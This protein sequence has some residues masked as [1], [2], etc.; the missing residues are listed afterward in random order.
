MLKRFAFIIL[1]CSGLFF[2]EN[3]FCYDTNIAHPGIAEIA[4]KVYNQ[5]FEQDLTDEEIG[6]IKQGT[7]EEDTPTRWM[8]HFYDPIYEKG[9]VFGGMTYSSAKNWASS[10]FTQT[11]YALGD[12]SWQRALDDIKKGDRKN[13]FKELGH[14]LHLIADMSVPAHTRNDV[15][16][17]DF[18]EKFVKLNW[19]EVL[20]KINNNFD[21]LN[22][23]S[24]DESFRELAVFS[25]NNFFSDDTILN[26]NYLSPSFDKLNKSNDYY[27]Y[28]IGQKSY[29]ILYFKESKFTNKVTE[30]YIDDVI[31]S[32]YSTILLPKA[33]AYSSGVIKL[34]I[35]E[36]N[37]IET[38]KIALPSSRESWT[39]FFN[40]A[41]GSL[42]SGAEKVY[43]LAK[44]VFGVKDKTLALSNEAGASP[45][46]K[47]SGEEEYIEDDYEEEEEENSE[48]EEQEDPAAVIE[49]PKTVVSKPQVVKQTSTIPTNI[50]EDDEDENDIEDIKENAAIINPTI[51]V[52]PTAPVSASYSSGG[53][54]SGGGSQSNTNT[55]NVSNTPNNN[56]NNEENKTNET[57]DEIIANEIIPDIIPPSAP[58]L[59]PIFS[60]T[61]YTTG[62]E[63]IISG[64]C[65]SDTVKILMS[66]SS[67]T[68][69]TAS[70][71]PIADFSIATSSTEWNRTVV[72]SPGIGYFFFSAVDASL[73]ISPT[74]SAVKIVRDNDSP[75]I[76]VLKTENKSGFGSTII[77]LSLSGEKD[78]LSPQTFYDIQYSTNTLEWVDYAT[79]TLDV[80]FDFNGIRDESYYFRVRAFDNLGNISAW[81]NETGGTA[82]KIGLSMEVVVSEVAWAGVFASPQ[83]EWFELYN[84]TDTD[85]DLSK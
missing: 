74:S 6:W 50:N 27:F 75:P 65:S 72:L 69:P 38:D 59:S 58:V 82:E 39:G 57:E 12:K 14:T 79:S 53:D 44:N 49:K 7:M 85:I 22:A 51:P 21:F 17:G 30:Y 77:H 66:F 2:S 19:N 10:P 55:N 84:N 52:V 80:E 35:D 68:I 31:L 9:L 45:N 24:L 47:L 54:S 13:A 18:Y 76:P 28:N 11:N 3:V 64:S 70:A 56:A 78:A 23:N 37:K 32:D 20:K 8:N 81:N 61:I 46:S 5:N 15:H 60:E 40:R 42:V 83:D 25:N 1:I 26:S 33:I 67:S 62:T 4:A 34:F 36:T 29:K 71:T 41:A 63:Y 48:D 16:L 73:N 43:D